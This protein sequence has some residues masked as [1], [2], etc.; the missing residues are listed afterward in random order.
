MSRSVAST[1]IARRS[2][3]LLIAL[4]IA[5]IALTFLTIGRAAPSSFLELDFNVKFD[6]TG[7][8]DW[9]NSGNCTYTSTTGGTETCAGSGG[10]FNGGIFNG[11][12]TVPTAPPRTAGSLANASIIDAK[13]IVDALSIDKHTACPT[14]AGLFIDGDSTSYTGAGS[15]KNGT[16]LS[17]DTWGGANNTPNKDDL[18]NVY[19]LAHRTLS[20]YEIFFGGE[21]VINNGDSHID[22]E[23]LQGTVSLVQDAPGTCAGHFTGNRT[24]GDMLLSVDFTNGGTLGGTILYQWHCNAD[25]GAQPPTGTVCNPPDHGPSVPHYQQVGNTAVTFGVNTVNI[26]CGGWV[27]RNADGTQTNTIATNELMEGGIDFNALGF[28]GCVSTFL[29]H[30]RSSGSFTATLKDFAVIPFNTCAHP[31]LTTSQSATV[32]GAPVSGANISVPVGTAVTDQATLTGQVGTPTGTVTYGL[33][34]NSTCTTLAASPAITGT[35]P[36][37]KTLS[38]GTITIVSTD[39]GINLSDGTGGGPMGRGTGGTKPP[40]GGTFPEGPGTG[41]IVGDGA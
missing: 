31:T 3:P 34:T 8:F 20:V 21:R 19:A 13:F 24:Q 9:A 36:Q 39:D 37:T 7:T 40:A 18:S 32:G 1:R 29:P 35:N 11:T 10:V 23:F 15:E 41:G 30:T 2:L 26:P 38:G 6:G 16:L 4:A 12:T 5:T 14:Q 28:N 25:P 33:Y 17:T 27:C 22:F